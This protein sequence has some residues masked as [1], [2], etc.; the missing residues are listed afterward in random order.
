MPIKKTS[1]ATDADT[2]KLEDE[3][4]D[5]I[6]KARYNNTSKEKTSM[7]PTWERPMDCCEK[8]MQ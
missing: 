4:F 1:K 3:S 6:F 2:M 7:S 5:A 8:T